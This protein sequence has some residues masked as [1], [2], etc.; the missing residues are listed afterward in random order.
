M[1]IVPTQEWAR[2]ALGKLII[3]RLYWDDWLVQ[4]GKHGDHVS[5]QW[6]HWRD[7]AGGPEMGCYRKSEHECWPAWVAALPLAKM[8][9]LLGQLNVQ[10]LP[11]REWVEEDL[12]AKFWNGQEFGLPR[13]QDDDAVMASLEK[14]AE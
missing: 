10:D 9:P 13:H 14:E 3:D 11:L 5:Y 7:D 2:Q 8:L 12:A 1:N 4:T 6:K